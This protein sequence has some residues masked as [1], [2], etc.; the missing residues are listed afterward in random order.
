MRED[1]TYRADKCGMPIHAIE[2]RPDRGQPRAVLQ[3]IHGM[4]EFI[5][6][7]DRF[8]SFMAENGFVVVGEDHPGHGA[9]VN[10]EGD[11]GYFGEPDGNAAVISAIHGLREITQKKYPD[12][13][14]A[15]LGHSMGSF[16]VQQY[17]MMYGDG[18]RAMIVMGTGWQSAFALKFARFI[19]KVQASRHGWRYRSPLL[20]RLSL[21]SANKRIPNP[22][23]K[24]DWLTK[25]EKIVAAYNA[26]PW[27]NFMFTVNAFDAMFKGIQYIEAPEHVKQLSPSLPVL[28]MSGGEDPVG[29]YGAGPKKAAA[30]Y[31]ACGMKDVRVKIYPGDRHE[32]LNEL[33]HEKPDGDI[34]A[35]LEETTVSD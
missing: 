3:I 22:K 12:L 25:D 14:Y 6:R 9:S 29:N 10:D 35:F 18:I 27:D 28:F 26:N 8:A 34:L 32:I 2:W 13:P 11:H 21:G 7:Y 1:F 5:G 33:D 17:V 16:L 23:T 19:C 4:I 15:I 24:N 31:R 30:H 20:T